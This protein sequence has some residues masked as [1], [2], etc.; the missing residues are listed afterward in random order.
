MY[1]VVKVF[2][3]SLFACL[4]L[5]LP[6]HPF[7]F[8]RL[9]W[10]AVFLDTYQVTLHDLSFHPALNVQNDIYIVKHFHCNSGQW[11]D[12]LSATIV[13]NS[14]SICGTETAIS[15]HP[16]KKGVHTTSVGGQQQQPSYKWRI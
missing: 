7:T 14:S 5:L 9:L 3:F 13:F 4:L 8:T 2:L 10:V 12:S 11:D 6:T 16:D 1:I 15:K